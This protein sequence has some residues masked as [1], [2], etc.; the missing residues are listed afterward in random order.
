MTRLTIALLLVLTAYAYVSAAPTAGFCVSTNGHTV[1]TTV[2][3]GGGSYYPYPQVTIEQ[4][5][6][7]FVV[8]TRTVFIRGRVYLAAV[9]G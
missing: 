3:D 7:G 5:D 2:L 8:E 1:E 6:V 9:Y 4:T